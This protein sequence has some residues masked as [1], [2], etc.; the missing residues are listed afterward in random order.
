MEG[1]T[2]QVGRGAGGLNRPAPKAR[3]CSVST[4]PHLPPP[5]SPVVSAQSIEDELDP[6]LLPQLLSMLT[7]YARHVLDVA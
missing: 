4:P 7:D 6:I 2:G 3:S 1:R 5:A